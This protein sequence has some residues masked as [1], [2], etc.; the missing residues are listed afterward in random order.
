[1]AIT[2]SGGFDMAEFCGGEEI[3]DE[4]DMP[5]PECG[6]IEYPCPCGGDGVDE[7]LIPVGVCGYLVPE[8]WYDIPDSTVRIAQPSDYVDYSDFE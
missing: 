1:M 6:G 5:C 8:S 4:G 3:L 2:P 7:T